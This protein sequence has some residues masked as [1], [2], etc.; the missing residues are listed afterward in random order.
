MEVRLGK[1]ADYFAHVG[2]I[3][4][5]LEHDLSVGDLIHIKGHQTDFTQ[6]VESMQIEHE[7][8]QAAKNGNDIGIKT[9]EKAHHGD[10]VFK[11]LGDATEHDHNVLP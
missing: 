5:R 9:K 6:T 11:V 10:T 2:A 7:E 8:V 1:V 4:L 3:R